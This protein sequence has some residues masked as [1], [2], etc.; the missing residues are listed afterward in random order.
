MTQ[1]L[2]SSPS[3]SGD[4]LALWGHR[5]PGGRGWASG[6]RS[7]TRGHCKMSN[8]IS[9]SFIILN[10]GIFYVVCG[11][12]TCRRRRSRGWCVRGRWGRWLRGCCSCSGPLMSPDTRWCWWPPHPPGAGHGSEGSWSTGH[13]R[14]CHS[15]ESQ[16]LGITWGSGDFSLKPLFLE[17]SQDQDWK[18]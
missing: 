10:W 5:G 6:C 7:W 4:G 17:S 13:S 14:A 16:T 1:W 3:L 2:T 15:A 18:Q 8:S 11:Q 9:Q 12:F